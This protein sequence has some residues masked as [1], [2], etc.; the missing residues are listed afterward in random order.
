MRRVGSV[1]KRSLQT[2]ARPSTTRELRL[3]RVSARPC[4]RP[5][6]HNSDG[7]LI[8][9]A[10]RSGRV[11]ISWLIMNRVAL[12]VLGLLTSVACNAANPPIDAGTQCASSDGVELCGGASSCE[13]RSNVNCFMDFAYEQ[14]F[15]GFCA[16]G[17]DPLGTR[18]CFGGA[19]DGFACL[20]VPG[21]EDA[22]TATVEQINRNA[23]ALLAPNG[24]AG[25]VREADLSL[26][27]E[28]EIPE[29]TSC[30]SLP[31]PTCGGACGDCPAGETCIGRSPTHPVG[32]CVFS[33]TCTSATCGSACFSYIVEQKAQ[34]IA[35][36]ACIF[37][38]AAECAAVASGL[39]GQGLCH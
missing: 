14:S 15:P 24:A 10:A 9:V 34:P 13:C 18:G 20:I 2:A 30:P 8:H 36:E 1:R 6:R 4:F 16:D 33:P 5:E 11:R 35:N 26:W 21:T 23:A 37:M 12:C 19:A 17:K 7:L 3:P 22:G 28:L 31:V 25:W 29:P 27:S 38:T 32:I 39:P